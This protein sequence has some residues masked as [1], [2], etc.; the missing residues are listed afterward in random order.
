VNPETGI[1][2]GPGACGD[3][4]LRIAVGA[5]AIGALD[6][7]EAREVR[8]HLAECPECQA[9]YASFVGVKRVMDIGLVGAPMPEPPTLE[10]RRKVR[11]PRKKLPFRTPAGTSARAPQR[12]PLGRRIVVGAAGLALVVGGFWAGHSGRPA[13]GNPPGIALSAVTQN[14]VTAQISYQDHGWGTSVTAR[15]SGTPGGLNCTLYVVAKNH[16]AVQLSNWRSVDG[17]PVDIPAATSLPP[18]QIDHFEVRVA[19]WGGY[20]ITVPMAS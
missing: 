11:K 10:D 8:R 18:A 13:P 3:E 1:G 16:D 2:T 6:P 7:D 14:G 15:M 5:L 17:K 12:I 9:E 19:V 4:D 20:D